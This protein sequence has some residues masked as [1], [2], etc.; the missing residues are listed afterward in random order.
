MNDL[1]LRAETALRNHVHSALR[2]AELEELRRERYDPS[3]TIERL[4]LVLR[5]YPSRFLILEAWNG[6]WLSNLTGEVARDP[7][8]VLVADP[9]RG[10]DEPRAANTLRESVRWLARGVDPRSRLDV[11]RWY[12]IAVAERAARAAVVARVSAEPDREAA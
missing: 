2:L 8:V 6:R 1:A 3:L 9:D 4:R 7:W 10:R 5:D 12:A 11:S